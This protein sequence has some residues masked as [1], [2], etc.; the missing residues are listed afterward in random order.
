MHYSLINLLL[1]HS[2]KTRGKH[3][4]FL[5]PCV[6]WPV[7]GG[8]ESHPSFSAAMSCLFS[9]VDLETWLHTFITALCVHAV[10]SA[11]SISDPLFSAAVYL[12]NFWPFMF[13][14]AL[15]LLSLLLV[16]PSA[17]STTTARSTGPTLTK[18][19]AHTDW[20]E[21]V[22]PSRTSFLWIISLSNQIL[23]LYTFLNGGE[24]H[25]I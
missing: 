21:K 3:S 10:P 1:T 5:V 18:W 4:L 17:S 22:L 7:Q 20:T 13:C 12:V 19:S 11:Q 25:N 8:L 9:S 15:N 2:P 6:Q 24:I 14:S 23:P 16:S